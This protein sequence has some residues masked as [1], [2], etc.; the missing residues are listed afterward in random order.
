LC[1]ATAISL[2]LSLFPWADYRQ[3]KGGVKVHVLLDQ[4]DYMPSFVTITN[5]K[6]HDSAISK[7]LNLKPGSTIA[8]DRRYLDFEQFNK[9]NTSKI[10]FVSRMK[11]NICYKTIIQGGGIYKSNV[12]SDDEIILTG[13]MTK[14]KYPKKLR[15]VTI[16]NEK[17]QEEI[18]ILTNNFKLI[19]S[20][21]CEIHKERWEIELFFKA[22]KQTF[23]VKTLIG[24][25][26]SALRI[27]IWTA[28]ISLLRIRWMHHMSKMKWS[29]SIISTTLRLNLST[30]RSLLT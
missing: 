25:S 23:N 14:M 26:E 13:T 5:A 27:Q 4:S 24:A 3:T 6:V 7:T 30:Y 10:F 1:Y 17:K 20:T 19:T 9:W 8:A 15:L 28:I 12:R 21:I 22:L 2:C 16:W 18:K 29:F 11:D